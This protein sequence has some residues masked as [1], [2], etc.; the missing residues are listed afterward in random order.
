MK[1]TYQPNKRRRKKKI[2]FRARMRT[3]G[4]RGVISRRRAKKRRTLTA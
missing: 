2:G 4:G 1:R 3:A